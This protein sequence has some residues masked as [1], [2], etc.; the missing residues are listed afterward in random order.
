MKGK[1]LKNVIA[2]VFAFVTLFVFS[3][4]NP[5]TVEAANDDSSNPKL[6]YRAHIQD[7]GWR[8]WTNQGDMAGTTGYK[9]RMEALEI[10]LENAPEAKLIYQAHVS[11]LGW[12]NPVEADDV[13]ETN[14]VGTTGQ[15]RQMEAIV[16]ELKGLEGYE[17][18]Y[19]VHVQDLGWMNWVKSGQVAGTT[20]M[21]LR[22]EAIEIRFTHTSH[23]FNDKWEVVRPATCQ[24]PGEEV[25]KCSYCDV[26]STN[27]ED[28]REVKA[29]D[30]YDKSIHNLIELE[31]PEDFCEGN[32]IMWFKY[33]CADC[34]LEFNLN[35]KEPLG[36]D[37]QETRVE[38]TCGEDGYVKN[39]CTRCGKVDGEV[40]V[41]P[42]TNIHIKEQKIIPAT[43]EENGYIIDMCT[44]C[45]YREEIHSPEIEQ[46]YPA[47]GHQDDG[48][49][50][51]NEDNTE[52]THC[53][54]CGKV[55]QTRAHQQHI[56]QTLE[57]AVPATCETDGKTEKKQC[58]ICKYTTGGYTVKALGHQKPEKI[59]YTNV[60]CTKCTETWNCEICGK[61]FSEEKPYGKG[62]NFEDGNK[63]K[64]CGTKNTQGYLIAAIY[65][66]SPTQKEP[67]YMVRPNTIKVTA[68]FVEGYE[69]EGW[70]N[71]VTDTYITNTLTF[72]VTHQY[73][74]AFIEARYKKI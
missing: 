58:T 10:N 62:H 44:Q 56:W 50:K 63:C 49:W 57:A 39:V 60:T 25:K 35:W 64:D 47:L 67:T 48:I 16:I 13:K 72:E 28:R 59:N 37:F 18:E 7:L 52:S 42:K 26:L 46:K 15:W 36:H 40:T 68:E 9:L 3:S 8:G 14:M 32:K 6:T 34:G 20:G 73:S 21:A 24:L 45:D 12:M 70:Y 74:N 66:N 38:A 61:E 30:M 71:K 31:E 22:I 69:F 11:D 4:M 51:K 19:R 41:L 23:V 43:C 5:S 1:L 65:T 17:I 27:P 33:R 53:T 2:I 55:M 29:T 54:R